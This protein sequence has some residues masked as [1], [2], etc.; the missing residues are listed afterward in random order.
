ME[1]IETEEQPVANV[2]RNRTTRIKLMGFIKTSLAVYFG[3]IHVTATKSQGLN[4]T[5]CHS[6]PAS[7][8]IVFVTLFA[9]RSTRSQRRRRKNRALSLGVVMSTLLAWRPH[10]WRLLPGKYT[11]RY[12]G[13]VGTKYE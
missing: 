6:L 11:K 5:C 7:G 13:F 3:I 8:K 2:V 10:E 4:A 1:G 12:L 9:A